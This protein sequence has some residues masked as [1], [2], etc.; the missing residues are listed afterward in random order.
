MN[1][2]TQKQ[3]KVLEYFRKKKEAVTP[4]QAAIEMGYSESSYISHE[5]KKLTKNKLL[6]KRGVGR[7]TTYESIPK[8]NEKN[9][10]ST[11]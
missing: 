7:F 5:L 9:L 8:Y 3:L 6:R 2:Y 1:N 10:V 11:R 4:K